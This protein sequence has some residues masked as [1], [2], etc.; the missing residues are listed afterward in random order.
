MVYHGYKN[1]VVSFATAPP[2]ELRRDEPCM[3]SQMRFE[4]LGHRI[5]AIRRTVA[6]SEDSAGNL[7][8]GSSNGLDSG[9]RDPSGRFG[10]A[11]VPSRPG[12]HAEEE[13]MEAITDLVRVGTSRRLPCG[14]AEQNSV[15]QLRNRGIIVTNPEGQ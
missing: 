9:M 1:G 3:K 15:Q 8:V 12:L 2:K 14:P 11:P 10:V 13:L 5:T 6:V 7:H 4:P